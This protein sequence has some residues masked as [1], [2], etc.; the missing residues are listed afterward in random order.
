M[1]TVDI[2][3]ASGKSWFHVPTEL[4]S[5]VGLW[6][7]HLTKHHPVLEWY[8]AVVDTVDGY[9]TFSIVP[10]DP[11]Y[12]L[13]NGFD[14]SKALGHPVLSQDEIVFPFRKLTLPQGMAV[15]SALVG[16]LVT[17]TL[18]PDRFELS[19]WGKAV[20]N[21]SMLAVRGPNMYA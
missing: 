14:P 21:Y 5:C 4:P 10:I 20:A 8:V 7:L 16:E 6:F 9:P 15:A 3:G 2:S 11:E 1:I 18:I 12:C 17:G 19:A 13:D